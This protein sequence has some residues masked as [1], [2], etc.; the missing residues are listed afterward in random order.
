MK[1]LVKILLSLLIL[2]FLFHEVDMGA[3][4]KT[5]KQANPL[6]LAAALGVQ[7]LSQTVAAWRW[8]LIMRKLGFEHDLGFYLRSYFKGTLFNQLLPTSIGGDAYRVAEVHAHGAPLKE[9]FYAIFIDR[10]VGLVGL[11]LLN[12]FAI[13][14]APHDLYPTIILYTILAVIL[15][16]LVGFVLLLWLHRYSPLYRWRFTRLF[17]ELSERFWR[18]Y[19]QPRDLLV[20]LGLS[21]L[22]H[23]LGMLVLFGIGHAVGINEPIGIYLALTP[24]AILLTILPI[25]FA[26]WGVRESTLIGLFMLIGTPEPKVLAMS[27]LYGIIL[28]FAALPGVVFYLQ[29]RHRW[30]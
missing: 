16:T 22:T 20:Q 30:L 14:W 11:L 18:V 27:L 15:G 28:V 21:L 5:M 13:L 9:A 10:I 29:S 4:L 6:L 23:L 17:A 26:G 3:A 24:I 8:T 12:L 2:A 19:H 1:N 7:L 25:T